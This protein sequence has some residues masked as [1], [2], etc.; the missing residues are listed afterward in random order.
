[1][2]VADHPMVGEVGFA[3]WK[4]G[5][6]EEAAFSQDHVVERARVA[7][8]DY[9][10]TA[11]GDVAVAELE[12]RIVGWGAREYEPDCI[13]DIWIDP[14]HQ[15]G[16]IGFALVSYFIERIAADGFRAAKIDTRATNTRA[17]RLYERA[18]FSIVRRG[19]TFD[20]ELGISLEQVHL[21]KHFG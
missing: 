18:G 19:Q 2:T 8:L 4:S 7:F 15:G 9:A 13:S 17:I 14:A 12:G 21:E 11:K 10:A 1:M 20:Q 6:T 16:G 3:A 5:S